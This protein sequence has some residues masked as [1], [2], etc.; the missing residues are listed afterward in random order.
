MKICV[1]GAGA[2]GGVLAGALAGAGHEVSVVARGANL[3]AIREQ[4]LRIH[5]GRRGNIVVTRPRAESDP[6]ALGE[7]DCVIVAVK[8]HSLGQVAAAIG[9]LLS[10]RTAVVTAMNGIPWWFFDRLPFG[11]GRLRLESLDA[12]GA[13][14]NAI[15]TSRVIGCVVH[16]A[17]SLNG[18]G[19]ITHTM[20]ARLILGE[21]GG[22]N[23][24]RTHAISAALRD[25]GFEVEETGSIEREFWV[26]L[27]GN[28][29]F[30]PV[31]ALTLATADRLIAD[32]L[33]K[34]YMVGIMREC[35]EIGRAIGVDADIDPEARM[36]MARKL[37]VFKPSM[38]QDLE[39]GKALEI[40]GLLTA[41]LEVAG[42]AGVAAPFT[43]ILLGLVRV[44]AQTTA[45]YA[46]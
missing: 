17:A 3:T 4:G 28:V 34:D 19:Q 39:A 26:K 32:P 2:V 11:G 35:L 37:G 31:A 23:S 16:L 6:A 15:A 21:P 36:E 46:A 20:G 27:L 38:L 30:N 18:P 8:G 44:R 9:P 25:A 24:E 7:Q 13:I 45:Q 33:V 1:F 12:D 5:D 42:K 14:A 40:D 41:T 10:P 22:A 43:R 29:S